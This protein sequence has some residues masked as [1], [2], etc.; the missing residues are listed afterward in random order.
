[1]RSHGLVAVDQCKFFE[2]FLFEFVGADELF[3][4]VLLAFL[5]EFIEG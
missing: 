1:M 5:L 4:F 3:D 2:G